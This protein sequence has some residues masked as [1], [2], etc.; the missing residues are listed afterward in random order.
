MVESLNAIGEASLL[1]AVDCVLCLRCLPTIQQ[2]GH[3]LFRAAHGL[4]TDNAMLCQKC[5][6]DVTL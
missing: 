5:W 3:H 6:P 1:F 2:R 4:Y